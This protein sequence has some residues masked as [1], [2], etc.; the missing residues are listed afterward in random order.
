MAHDGE[1]EQGYDNNRATPD[2]VIVVGE[3][4]VV[5]VSLTWVAVGQRVAG[6]VHMLDVLGDL[7]G[8][9]VRG[10]WSAV[11]SEENDG[12]LTQRHRRRREC[13]EEVMM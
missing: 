3:F 11:K 8:L 10:T 2:G 1:R 5:L 9:V 12:Q 7:L 6:V 4:A 13:V